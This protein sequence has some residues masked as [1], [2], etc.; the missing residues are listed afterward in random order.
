MSPNQGM[1]SQFYA[2]PTTQFPIKI[3]YEYAP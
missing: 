1:V 3:I 2:F